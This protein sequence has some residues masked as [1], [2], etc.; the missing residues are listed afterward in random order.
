[1]WIKEMAKKELGVLKGARGWGYWWKNIYGSSDDDDDIFV[2]YK[3]SNKYFCYNRSVTK[4]RLIN[5]FLNLNLH[6]VIIF[7]Y[8]LAW[9]VLSL[10]SVPV[11]IWVFLF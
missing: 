1:M 10:L 6:I 7:S 11:T 5:S 4:I 8:Y 3:S 2:F 9:V